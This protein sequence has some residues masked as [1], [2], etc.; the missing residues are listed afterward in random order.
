MLSFNTK[1]SKFRMYFIPKAHLHLNQPHFKCSSH[2]WLVATAQLC[3]LWKRGYG[4]VV[5][6][7]E[8]WT[9]VQKGC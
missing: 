4:Y 1:T 8:L 6:K 2:M 3:G 9:S 5:A 7:Q